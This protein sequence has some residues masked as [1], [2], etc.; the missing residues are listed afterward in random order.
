VDLDRAVARV[1]IDRILDR[2]DL[3]AVADRIDLDRAVARVDI[4]PILDRA[5]IVGLARYVVQEI[6]LP[7][8]VRYSTGSVTS[9]MVRGLRDQSTGADQAVARVVDRVLRRHGRRTVDRTEDD[10]VGT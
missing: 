5:D 6:D 7:A 10:G 2:V 3:D 1:D 9:E 4:D 8:L